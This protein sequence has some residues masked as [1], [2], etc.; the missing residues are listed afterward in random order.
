M[1]GM[2]ATEQF[3]ECSG[4]KMEALQ[5]GRHNAKR[6]APTSG[7]VSRTCGACAPCRGREPRERRSPDR[8][9]AFP[10]SIGICQQGIAVVSRSSSQV[11]EGSGEDIR[12][13]GSAAEAEWPARRRK[14]NNGLGQRVCAAAISMRL[15]PERLALYRAASAWLTKRLKSG[16]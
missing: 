10:A 14:A 12:A 9:R 15:R 13:H 6:F 3:G 4:S 11:G 8:A 5:D 2:F 1:P 7:R 16:A